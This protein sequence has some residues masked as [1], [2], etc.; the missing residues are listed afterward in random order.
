MKNNQLFLLFFISGI[1][2]F[3]SC[4]KEAVGEKEQTVYNTDFSSDDGFWITGNRPNG[5]ILMIGSGYYAVSTQGE[6]WDVWLK[7]LFEN[8]VQ[9]SAIET[10]LKVATIGEETWGNGGLVWNLRKS[11]SSVASIFY[12][13]IS[14]NGKFAIGAYPN[15]YNG[16]LEKY[17]DWKENNVI[18]K[19]AFNKLRIENIQGILHFHI[20]GKEVYSMPSKKGNLLDQVGLTTHKR[21]TMLVDYF[22]AVT[23]GQ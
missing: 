4:K 10:S 11:G 23:I 12:F 15:G 17:V 7:S 6:G 5:T 21:T 13:Y 3:Q 19:E 20:N 22:K 9:R 18:K 16:I 1:L 8:N 14:H 2:S